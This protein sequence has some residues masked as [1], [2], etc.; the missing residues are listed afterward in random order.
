MPLHLLRSACRPALQPSPTPCLP[1]ATCTAF[2]LPLQ[3]SSVITLPANSKV[4]LGACMLQ[5]GATYK[6]IVIPAGSEVSRCGRQGQPYGGWEMRQAGHVAGSEVGGRRDKQ[7]MT[8]G[9][10]LLSAGGCVAGVTR[11]M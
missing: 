10:M 4:L 6:Q 8:N 2:S 9:I 7:G 5:S 1:T 3:P 11:G